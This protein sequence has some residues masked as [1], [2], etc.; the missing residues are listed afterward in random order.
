MR[1][2]AFWDGDPARPGPRA[3][4]LAPLAALYATATA[5][6]VA[7]PGWRAPVPVICV[8]NLNAGGT[9]KTPTAIALMQRLVERGIEAHVV[10]RGHGGRLEGPV[11]VDERRHAADE[12]GDEPLLLAAFGPVWVARD[13]AAGAQAAVAAGARALILDDGF[14]N[15]AL[16]KDLSIVVV[17]AARGFGNGRVI[18]AG[19]LR[20]PVPAG[21][22]RADMVL[23]IGGAAQQARFSERWGAQLAGLPHLTG[24]LAPLMTGMVWE[25]MPVLAFAGIGHPEKFFATLKGLGADLRRA[26][27]LGDHQPLTPALMARLEQEARALPAQLVTT[28]K[29]AVRLPASFRSKVLTLPVRLEWGDT[30]PLDAAL[31]RLGLTPR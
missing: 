31:D 16:D 13:R 22:A 29:D 7:R 15:P 19:P 14:Q 8:G 9:G 28:E 17:D 1:A 3:R 26:E 11:R 20:E 4:A 30:A 18:P 6:R 27:A 21:L 25:R 5:R 24:R 2:P 12:V 23:S 10:S